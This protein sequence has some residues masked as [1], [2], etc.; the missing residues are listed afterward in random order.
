MSWLVALCLFY[1]AAAAWWLIRYS[2]AIV[3]RP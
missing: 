1:A 3:R 2:L